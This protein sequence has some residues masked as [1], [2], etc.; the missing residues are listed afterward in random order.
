MKAAG[1]SA[2]QPLQHHSADEYQ[3]NEQ[4]NLAGINFAIPGTPIDIP[5]HKESCDTS[6]ADSYARVR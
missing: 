5:V 2:N 1:K 4:R 6:A 3:P